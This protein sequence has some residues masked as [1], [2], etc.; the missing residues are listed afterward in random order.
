LAG[1]DAELAAVRQAWSEPRA[2]LLEGDAGL[3]KSRLMA[4]LLADVLDGV[5]MGVGRP[6]DVAAPA[7]IVS[8]RAP[9]SDC[10][11]ELSPTCALPEGPGRGCVTLWSDR[12]LQGDDFE[13]ADVASGS[14]AGTRFAPLVGSNAA[15]TRP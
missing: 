1:R 2:V 6:G 4:E 14:G 7:C 15:H 5:L 13:R 3:G 10:P 11:Q 9:R 12:R 8:S